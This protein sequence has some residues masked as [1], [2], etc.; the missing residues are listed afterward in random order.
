[1]GVLETEL[2]SYFIGGY[3]GKWNYIIFKLKLSKGYE[4]YHMIL[5]VLQFTPQL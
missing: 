5:S 2:R 1:M 3:V 4:S